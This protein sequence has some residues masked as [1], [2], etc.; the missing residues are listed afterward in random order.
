M[1][2]ILISILVLTVSVG[3]NAQKVK[4]VK[5]KNKNDSLS[6]AFGIS[7]AD[8]LSKQKIE[9]LNP[10]AIGRAFQD[11]YNKETKI[12]AD[13][14]NQLIQNHFENQESKKYRPTVEEGEKFLKEN[15][16]K[17]GVKVLESGLQ[18]KV[19]TEGN[20]DTPTSSDKVKVH[21]EGTL[22]DGTKFDSSYDR[23]EPAEFGVTQVIKGWTEA[24]QL[25]K[26]GSVWMLYIPY[27]LAYGSRQAGQHIKPFST[28]IFKVELISIVK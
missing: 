3:I 16:N 4:N 28:L 27:D 7:I 17:K 14:A 25:M 5:M 2:K 20:G 21:Y 6:Y 10:Q 11:F 8:N 24:L 15:A 18:Y 22:I 26:E 12:S 19:I 23:E 1:K 9:N 13:D